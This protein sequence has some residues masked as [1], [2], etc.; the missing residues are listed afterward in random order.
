VSVVRGPYATFAAAPGTSTLDAPS[1]LLR[2][3]LDADILITAGGQTALEAAAA[4]TP[5]VALALAA[6]QGK[7]VELLAKTG[8][9]VAATHESLAAA[10]GDL[11]GERERSTLAESAQNAIDGLGAPRVAAAIALQVEQ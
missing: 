10:L 11:R 5:C 8:V 1:S 4:G 6:D 2:P 7:Q 9:A 3:L